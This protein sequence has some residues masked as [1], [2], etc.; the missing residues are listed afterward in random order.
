MPEI[1]AEKFRWNPFDLTKV[2]P[3]KDYPVMEVGIME[4]NRN[5]MNYFA[6]VE[7]AAFEPSNIVPGI[8]FSPDKMLQ[9]AFSPMQIPT[10]T[11]LELTMHFFR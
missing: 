6:E 5:P 3:H 1:E 2:W 9:A 10:V 4:L 7:Q 11:G 8:S